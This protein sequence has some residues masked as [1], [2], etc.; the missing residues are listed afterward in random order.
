MAEA[1][2]SK[3]LSEL[4]EKGQQALA[5]IQEVLAS[6]KA[7]AVAADEAQKQAAAS[8]A[9]LQAKIA[10]LNNSAT[11]ALAAGTQIEGLQTVIAAKSEHI[12]GAQDHADK[13]RSDLDKALTAAKQ[14]ANEVDA[15]RQ[16]AKSAADRADEVLVAA[17]TSRASVDSAIA[18]INSA[19]NSAQE[20]V[21]KAK[22][23]GDT[24][25]TD[26]QAKI[27]QINDIA[28]QAAAASAKITT[29]QAV[30][31]TKS[32]HIEEAREHATKVRTELDRELTAATQ[33]KT[34]AEALRAATE[35][36]SKD[37]TESLALINSAKSASDTEGA[38][39]ALARKSADSSAESLKGLAE[40]AQQVEAKIS[41]YE[42][43]LFDLGR[44]SEAKLKEIESLL[45][46][47]TST[48]LAH[49]FNQRR[50]SFLKPSQNWQRIFVTSILAIVTLTGWTLYHTLKTGVPT[51]TYDELLRM[52]LSRL[53]VMA[54]L[55]W[56]AL[57]SSHESA[58]AKRL[59]E[60]YGYKAAV[61]TSFLGF[62]RQMSEVGKEA[63]EN[64]PLAKL[65]SDTLDTIAAPPGRIYDK[66]AM[67]ASPSSELAEA[68]KK[69][70]QSTQGAKPEEKEEKE[71]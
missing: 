35:I 37:A 52:W 44:Q 9:D 63:A 66:H 4:M 26:Y 12:Q 32:E 65:C 47:A 33:Q 49:A 27:T 58:L 53:P 6:A 62:H 31:V 3:V 41:D 8:L 30:I 43:K 38:A 55:V 18:S 67:T 2:D 42:I 36:A 71:S 48:G 51:M 7:A 25:Q 69:A 13:V 61:A 28:A 68:L 22:A 50:I 21:E 34:T 17:N 16:R 23:A 14:T 1:S 70:L 15:E 57:H 19:Q 24:I 11:R 10:E 54:A 29:D 46:G 5:S 39:I 59:E 56:L 64:K 40:K 60:D 20:S 45:P